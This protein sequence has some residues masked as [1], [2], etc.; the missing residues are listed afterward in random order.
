MVADR[1]NPKDAARHCSQ[2]AATLIQAMQN[3]ENLWAL[4]KLAQGLLAVATSLEPKDTAAMLTN[5]MRVRAE[6][7]DPAALQP[8]AQGLAAVAARMEPKDADRLRSETA[9]TVAQVI[10][11]LIQFMAKT[12]FPYVDKGTGFQMRMARNE[13]LLAQGLSALLTRVDPPESSRR[14]AVVIGLVGSLGGTGN[15]LVAFATLGPALEPLPC[16]LST[17]ELVNLLKQPTCI[18]LAR[19]VILDQLQNRYRRL[20]NDQWAFVRFAQEQNLGLDFT[21]PPHPP[22]MSAPTR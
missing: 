1:I 16:S 21:T 10:S 22:E 5:A 19:R 12:K 7:P 3:R 9:A 11:G 18:G 15:P 17:P 4:P 14:L 13:E 8:L 2:A 6:W 20:F